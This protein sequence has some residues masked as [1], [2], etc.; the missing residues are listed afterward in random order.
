MMGKVVIRS[1]YVDMLLPIS[2]QPN[3]IYVSIRT[4]MLSNVVIT[5]SF[6]PQRLKPSAGGC[7]CPATLRIHGNRD[8]NILHVTV[9]GKGQHENH[10]DEIIGRQSIAR[11][12]H[13]RE[14]ANNR[15]LVHSDSKVAKELNESST[16]GRDV[17]IAL[18]TKSITAQ[19]VRNERLEY[20]LS[21]I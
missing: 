15:S 7:V 2:D 3:Q 21:D 14:I 1:L 12:N 20:L 19:E 5:T 6:R 10:N 16:L 9:W 13:I 8:K 4:I 18:R 11:K 17:E